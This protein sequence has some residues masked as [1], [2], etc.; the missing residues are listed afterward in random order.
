MLKKKPS[1]TARLTI[2]FT[3]SSVTLLLISTFYLYW[4]L[5]GTLEQRDLSFFASRIDEIRSLFAREDGGKALRFRIEKEWPARTAQAFFVRLIGARDQILAESPGGGR[6]LQALPT[7]REKGQLFGKRL[8]SHNLLYAN[9]R[10]YRTFLSPVKHGEVTY[11]AQIALDRTRENERLAQ[12]RT[13]IFVVLACCLVVCSLVCILIT[14]R[15]LRPIREMEQRAAQITSSN[16]DE[17]IRPGDMPLELAQLAET[18]NEMLDRL[19]GS[20][21]RLQRFSA[22]IA[23]ELRTPI[24]NISGEI[25]VTLAKDRPVE[26]YKEVLGSN[27]E[28]CARITRIIDSLLF[29]AQAENP[30]TTLI[31]EP[32][33]LLKELQTV[34]EFYEPAA[35]ESGITCQLK[36]EGDI[37]VRV[38]RTLFQRAVGNIL[39]NAIKK[40]DPS[41]SIEISAS[42]RRGQVE[43]A[44]SDTGTGI[45]SEHLP[46]L[47]DRFYRV[48]ASRS[49]DSGG[50]GL[51][52]AIVKS[53]A[54]IHGGAVEVS[55]QLGAGTQVRLSFPAT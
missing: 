8:Y 50:S 15:G 36:V 46:Y 5:V 3:L 13:R 34:L 41:G 44:I 55:S 18:F 27:L 38:E 17:K 54:A 52:L 19:R 47:F 48:D 12:Y 6:I 42:R 22:D 39:S 21:E 43:I 1:L 37:S 40:T 31:K 9:G 11:Y 30:R 53:I 45:P 35:T 29:L 2:G 32:I 16:L 14:R 20:F 24:N 28:E 7:Q 49:K 23:H 51:G 26:H 4:S 10:A 33:N 25:Q